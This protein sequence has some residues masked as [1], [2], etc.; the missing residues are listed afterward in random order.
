MSEQRL[1]YANDTTN[2]WTS[3]KQCFTFI[4]GIKKFNY[5]MYDN[6]VF[7]KLYK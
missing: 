5:S 7:D 6:P 3:L 2:L 1:N 4:R